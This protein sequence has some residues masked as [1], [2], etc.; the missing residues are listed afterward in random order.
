MSPSL[1]IQIKLFKILFN[2][3]KLSCESN[4]FSECD[5][6]NV[7]FLFCLRSLGDLK[8]LKVSANSAT[9]FNL[10][11]RLSGN[12]YGL[13]MLHNE[14]GL[15]TH[16]NESREQKTEFNALGVSWK[17]RFPLLYTEQS[18]AAR[19]YWFTYGIIYLLA[20]QRGLPRYNFL[21]VV[22]NKIGVWCLWTLESERTCC[23]RFKLPHHEF[24][25][26]LN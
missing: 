5:R 22:V 11:Q 25:L 19:E 9:W 4:H 6:P 10:F 7:V 18:S 20:I 16:I 23:V 12:Y 17:S 2:Y 26:H 3:G 14:I 15:L 21:S 1:L 24:H 13:L 8:K